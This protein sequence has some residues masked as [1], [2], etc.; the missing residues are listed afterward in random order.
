MHAAE[1]P[2]VDS[3]ACE[4]LAGRIAKHAFN[5]LVVGEFKRGKSTV[6]NAL[7]GSELLP[8]GVVPLTS[9]VTILQYGETPS[10]T[11]YTEDAEPT[12]ITLNAIADYVTERGNPANARRVRE[13]VVEIPADALR[14]GLRLVDTP[15]IGS[16]HQ[17]NSDVTRRYLP[18][19]DAVIFV[20]SADQP[21][22]RSELDFLAEIRRHA[23]KV[24]CVLNKMDYLA[25]E[26]QEEAVRFAERAASD[27]L[28]S[29]AHVFPMSARQALQARLG[30]RADALSASGL[31]AFVGSL[32]EFLVK[33]GGDVW[34]ASVRAQSLRLLSEGRLAA[35]LQLRALTSPMAILDEHLNTLAIRKLE[36]GQSATDAC[37][38][39]DAGARA[40][41]TE[42]I[43]PGLLTFKKRLTE[44]LQ[45]DLRIWH[46]ELRGHGS[47]PLRTIL[48]ERT[49][50]SIGIA[51][52]TWEGEADAAVS[53]TFEALTQRLMR[54]LQ[55]TI[56][57]V[58]RYFAEA[59]G[60]QFSPIFADSLWSNRG[61]FNVKTWS[62]P[63]GLMI[64]TTSLTDALPRRF[65]HPLILREA[66]KRASDLVEMHAG[67]LRHEF[68]ERIR[69][70]VRGFE[71]ELRRRINNSLTGI[72][73][74]IEQGKARQAAGEQTTRVRRL[75]LSDDIQRL[76]ALEERTQLCRS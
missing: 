75:E 64:L 57:D 20:A 1:S 45:V 72:T 18:H 63:P 17:H 12:R 28:G 74:A 40:L 26:D 37:A 35:E 10:A 9:V 61:G 36:L 66:L 52:A 69:G 41:V 33:E 34:L 62:E 4:E 68:E 31:P 30:S 8:M 54:R 46:E 59:F 67:R 56:D 16:V 19:A 15:G 49:L 55:N 2:S 27:A 7:L 5:L 60:I 47:V 76:Q 32:R 48:E 58:L 21:M 73:S 22:S 39:L 42:R 24:L 14:D 50:A 6:I 51:C 29:P 65:S 71:Q 70:N 38:V 25:P 43:E 23:G 44:Q 3:R 53:Q 11:V 13:V